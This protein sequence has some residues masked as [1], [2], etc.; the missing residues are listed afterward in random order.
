MNV[1]VLENEDQFSNLDQKIIFHNTRDITDYFTKK[2]YSV[3]VSVLGDEIEVKLKS[4]FGMIAEYN[5]VW[6]KFVK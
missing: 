2:G 6:A 3:S 5:G 1:I 4:E